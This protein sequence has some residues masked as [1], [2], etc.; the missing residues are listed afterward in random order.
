MGSEE[1]LFV[2]L[3]TVSLAESQVWGNADAQTE[4]VVE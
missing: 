3:M 4:D 2:N 1:T